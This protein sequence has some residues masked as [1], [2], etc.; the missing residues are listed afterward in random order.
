MKQRL[1]SILLNPFVIALCV[2][3]TIIACLPNSFSKYKVELI[4]KEQSNSTESIIYFNDL[5]GDHKSEKI[6]AQTNT[7]GHASFLLYKSNGDFLDQFN[8]LGKFPYLHKYLWFV[9]ADANGIKEIYMISQVRDSVFLNITKPFEN[10]ETITTRIFVDTISKF[11]NAYDFR[12]SICRNFSIIEGLANEVVF[13]LNTGFSANPR[14]TY[15]YDYV[16][17]RI[18]KSA[19]LTNPAFISG[20]FNLDDDA[21]NEFIIGNHASANAI[22]SSYSKRSDSSSWLTVL[23]H[24]LNFLFPPIEFKA[25]GGFRITKAKKENQNTLIALFKS[26]QHQILPSKLLRISS[27][28][29][30]E[31]EFVLPKGTYNSLF[32]FNEKLFTL[33][34]R[35]HNQLLFFND[36][37]KV[38]KT[39]SLNLNI[40]LLHYIDIDADGKK[41]W[42]AFHLDKQTIT[43]YRHNFK[44]PVSFKYSGNSKGD[45][46]SCG[47][48]QINASENQLYFQNA[49]VNQLFLYGYNTLYAFQYLIYF[50]IYLG[51]LGLVLL[52]LK[53]QDIREA[54]KR[55]I[56]KEISELQIKTIK[57][58]V[59]PHFVFNA[60]NTISEMTLMDNKLEADTYISQFSKFMRKTLQHSDKIAT[61][62]KEELAYTENFIKLQQIRFSNRFDYTIAIDKNVKLDTKIPKH[63]LFTYVENAIKHGLVLRENGMLNINA[64]YKND[65]LILSVEDNG[66]GLRH[67]NSNKTN[68]TGNGLLIM[69]QIFDLYS[70]LNKKEIKHQLIELVDDL[71]NPSGVKFE[72]KILN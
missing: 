43:I 50:G 53:G 2:S 20:V 6:V 22:D 55:A 72:I 65:V 29:I 45:C 64:N 57:N 67:K 63:A 47:I 24:D 13:N 38:I 61:T 44:H 71:G 66:V 27:K 70:K 9:D 62:L 56:E 36:D 17:H 68:S 15:K 59:D 46:Q 12:L 51:V 21:D 25:L 58:Q 32:P 4:K 8:V 7:L 11:N 54:R 18:I 42:L 52:V 10:K 28:G 5:D 14:H 39:I 1:I 16:N 19:H 3:I 69:E 26:R 33:Y 23:D 30:I 60:I 35:E 49:G 37:L 41:E 40:R 34:E 48:K 31:K